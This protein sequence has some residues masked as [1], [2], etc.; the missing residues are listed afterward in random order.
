[1]GQGFILSS[2]QRDTADGIELSF[3]LATDQGPCRVVVPSQRQVFLV[4]QADLARLTACWQSL[5]LLPEICPLSLQTFEGQ[6]VAAVYCRSFSQWRQ[7]LGLLQAAG[8]PAYESDIKLTERFLMERFIRGALAFSGVPTRCGG[9]WQLTT[10]RLA[11]CSFRPRLKWASLDIECSPAGELYSIGLVTETDRQVLMVG[12]PRAAEAISVD[13]VAHERGLLEALCRWMARHDPDVVIGWNV[14]NFDCR[15]LLRRAQLHGMALPLGRGG[16]VMSWQAYRDNS[17]QGTLSCP[18]RV[19]LDGIE[20]LKTATYQFASY[21]LEAVSQ[22]LLGEGKLLGGDGAA[23]RGEE[24]TRLFHQDPLALARYNLQDCLLVQR[25]FEHARLLEFAVERSCLTGLALERRG[26][27][28]AAFTNLYLPGLHRAGYVAPN[29]EAIPIAPSPGGYVMDSRPGLYQH[30]LVLDFKSLYP[31]IIRTFRIDPLGLV[32]GL[33]SPEEDS[34]PGFRGARFSRS[35][36]LLPAIIGQ[37]WQARDAAK[38]Q[39]NGP[40]SQAIKI[41]MNAMYGVL[42]SAGC[43]FHDS[44]LA[45]SITLRG[46]EIMKTTRGWIEQQGYQV[47]YGDTDSTFV[48]LQDC[49]DKQQAMR[50]GR[51]LAEGINRYWRQTLA[52]RWRLTSYL[53]IEFETCFRRFFMPTIRGRETGSKKRYAGLKVTGEGEQLVFKGLENVRTDWTEMARRFQ[54]T[55]YRR[56]FDDLPVEALIRCT[57]ADIRAGRLDDQLVY[58]KRLRRP[59]AE[60]RKNVPPHVRAARLAEAEE[61]RRGK[62]ARRRSGI[63]YVITVNG[64]EPLDY[65]RS[66]IDYEHYIDKQLKPIADAILMARG[67]QFEQLLSRQLGLF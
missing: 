57:V 67:E 58:R 1:L 52:E 28:V 12:A 16:E 47:I 30:V 10:A 14:V 65:R 54:E 25:I 46:H 66:P 44:R 27:S 8:L 19:V 23:N 15:L 26:G 39:H 21:S 41:I 22:A 5:V 50:T 9:A 37:L 62:R 4:R 6:P 43:R 49:R 33:R 31:S 48:W 53:E 35:R 24:I 64:P 51:Q 29:L 20:L 60:Y 59:L 32:E 36:H 40:L 61:G 18:G 34:I 38:Q 45:S 2:H 13:W 7:A 55:L 3:W 11:P 42:G 56:V 17:G 63:A